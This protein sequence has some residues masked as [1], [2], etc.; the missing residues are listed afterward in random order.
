MHICKETYAKSTIT[1]NLK[2]LKR[3]NL[4]LQKIRK[5]ILIPIRFFLVVIINKRNTL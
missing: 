5:K 4:M 1:Y 2:G 3:G